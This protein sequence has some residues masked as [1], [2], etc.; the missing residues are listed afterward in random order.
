MPLLQGVLLQWKFYGWRATESVMTSFKGG[1]M[2]DRRGES[3]LINKDYICLSILI[4]TFA[5]VTL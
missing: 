3:W 1:G 2:Q 5:L 4:L